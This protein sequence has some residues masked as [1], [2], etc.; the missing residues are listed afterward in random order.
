MLTFLFVTQ[1]KFHRGFK[2]RLGLGF[3]LCSKC[4]TKCD[5]ILCVMIVTH[6]TFKKTYFSNSVYSLS[7]IC[8]KKLRR[9]VAG[10]CEN[11]RTQFIFKGS[12]NFRLKKE[13]TEILIKISILRS[14]RRRILR[15]YT[16]RFGA[17]SRSRPRVYP[18]RLNS[19]VPVFVYKIQKQ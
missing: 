19:N 12:G 17:N 13:L 8:K 18:D 6:Y 5:T 10:N 16:G 1:N 2:L 11:F 4:V 14:V 3:V 9:W 15:T 7:I